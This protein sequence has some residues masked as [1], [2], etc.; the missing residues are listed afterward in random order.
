MVDVGKK[1]T[2]ARYAVASALVRMK[3][4]AVSAVRQGATSKGDVL[5]VA[6]VAAI[7]AAKRT[8]E[9]IPACHPIGLT[10]VLVDL[11]LLSRAVRVTVRA[12]A[13]DRTGVEMEALVGASVAALTVYDMLK[14]LD[15]DMVIERV[16]LEAKGGGR[17]GSWERSSARSVHA[18]GA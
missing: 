9:L 10:A 3:P 8:F 1:P 13:H 2:T 11:A 17:S 7:M 5:A 6:R 14:G 4:A 16:Q 15:R 12:E 18:R